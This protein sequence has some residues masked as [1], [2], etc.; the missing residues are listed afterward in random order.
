MAAVNLLDHLIDDCEDPASYPTRLRYTQL[1][2]YMLQRYEDLLNEQAPRIFS[3]DPT[4]WRIRFWDNYDGKP[5]FPFSVH[6]CTSVQAIHKYLLCCPQADPV[7]RHVFIEADHSMAPLDCSREMLTSLFTFHQVMPQF[8][9]IVLSF[10]ALPGRNVPT[11]VQR[12]IFQYEQF[13]DPKDTHQ[14]NIPQLG[15]SGLEIR[16]CYNLWSAE[17]SDHQHF[18]WA[19]RQ[20]GLY[21][22]FDIKTGK[23]TWIHVK[24]NSV[25]QER[26]KE[27]TSWGKRLREK[28]LQT[29]H[30]SFKA[31][32]MAHL[33]VFEWCT[34]GWRP[35]LSHW[36]CE[37]TEILTKFREAPIKHIDEALQSQRADPNNANDF[38][39]VPRQSSFPSTSRL[40]PSDAQTTY[41]PF[42]R[43]TVGSVSTWSSRLGPQ[44][45]QSNL[46]GT[47]LGPAQ[48][49]VE[50]GFQSAAREASN[51]NSDPYRIFNEFKIH[52]L[53]RLYLLSTKLQEADMILNL[54]ASTLTQIVGLYQHYMTDSDTPDAIR[55]GCRAAFSNFAQRTNK[56][57]VELQ[58][59]RPRIATLISLLADG[60]SLFNAFMNFKNTE[61]TVYV[62]KS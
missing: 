18:R 10:G 19:I 7:C 5:E 31:T 16:H 54:N 48:I 21:H 37:I 36:E 6:D 47:T 17:K 56:I 44:R 55:E 1:L 58:N 24:A 53:Q 33:I 52:D 35:Y 4:Y 40:N 27:A 60:K 57:I 34:E 25:L 32:L 49:P 26:I 61:L 2:P 8:L 9:D 30:G 51:G 29:V 22:S 38:Q 46:T 41:T 42:R 13:T 39:P 62:K 45:I 11:A 3:Q 50:R 20:A 43:D 15:R 59:E 28:D 14:Y 12:C 23:A